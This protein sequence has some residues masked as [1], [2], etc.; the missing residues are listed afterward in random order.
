MRGK[1][2][3]VAS[4]MTGGFLCGLM[5]EFW[6]FWAG[7]KWV[8]SVPFFDEWKLF[9]MP[10]LG[11]FGFPPFAVECWILYHLLRASLASS[12][13]PVRAAL[14]AGMLAFSLVMFRA[15][16]VNTVIRFA[17]LAHGGA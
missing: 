10:V 4:L 8:Y 5:W 12:G 15:I 11:F 17:G 13:T 2:S 6:N 7:S 9:E 14:W 1:C 16:D 3:R